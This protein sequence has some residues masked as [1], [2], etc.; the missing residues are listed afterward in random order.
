VAITLAFAVI[1]PPTRVIGPAADTFLPIVTVPAD[2]LAEKIP[3]VLVTVA[4]VAVE[5]LPEPEKV[6]SPVACIAPV[7]ATDEPPVI[8]SVPAEAVRE[9]APSYVVFGAIVMLVPA[10]VLPPIVTVLV[11]DVALTAPAVA[12]IGARELVSRAVLASIVTDVAAEIALVRFT[13]RPVEV[14]AT[15]EPEDVIVAPVALVI[16]ADPEMVIAPAAF[17]A[18]VGA[19]EVPP[20]IANVVPAV[21]GPAP[22]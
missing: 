18:P 15:L 9:P 7:G 5:I 16:A 20:E 17:N 10:I 13:V 1:V 14:I 6:I 8:E 2:E 19:T 11:V 4:F 12:V 3:E 22:A 21:T